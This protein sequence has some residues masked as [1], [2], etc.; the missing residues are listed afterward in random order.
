MELIIYKEE[1]EMKGIMKIAAYT[2]LAGAVAGIGVLLW[3]IISPRTY[4]N[5]INK[6]IRRLDMYT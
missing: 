2:Y 6:W 3:S 4:M 5:A 1:K